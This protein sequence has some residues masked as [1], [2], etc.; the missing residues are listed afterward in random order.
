MAFLGEGGK[1]VEVEGGPSVEFSK[2]RA[3]EHFEAGIEVA[4]VDY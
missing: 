3:L 2:E 4:L 1:G